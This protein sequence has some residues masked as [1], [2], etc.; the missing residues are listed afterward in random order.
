MDQRCAIVCPLEDFCM[1]ME[2]PVWEK[3]LREIAA[4]GSRRGKIVLTVSEPAERSSKYLL[5]SPVF[6]WLGEKA[7][8]DARVGSLRPLYPQLKN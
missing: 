2:E 4:D 1:V 6:A 8:P 7:V 5:G 3:R